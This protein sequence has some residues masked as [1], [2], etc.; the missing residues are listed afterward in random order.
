MALRWVSELHRPF[1]L[2]LLL[3]PLLLLLL[4]L[5]SPSDVMIMTDTHARHVSSKRWHQ[6]SNIYHELSSSSCGRD[7]T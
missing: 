6:A 5:V 1:L 3:L 2:L 4:L 7:F